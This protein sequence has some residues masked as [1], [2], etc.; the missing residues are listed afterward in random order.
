MESPARMLVDFPGDYILILV[1]TLWT[2][3]PSC[4]FSGGRWCCLSLR[5]SFVSRVDSH[6]QKHSGISCNH[7]SRDWHQ[8]WPMVKTALAVE[9]LYFPGLECFSPARHNRVTFLFSFSSAQSF[10]RTQVLFSSTQANLFL[11]LTYLIHLVSTSLIHLKS[12]K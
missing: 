3:F 8:A 4:S 6:C 12:K 2:R 10:F 5:G 1:R 9:T 7:A 11:S